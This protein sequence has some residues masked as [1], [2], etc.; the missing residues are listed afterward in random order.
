MSK[1]KAEIAEPLSDAQL[2]H[3]SISQIASIRIQAELL[4]LNLASG[5]EKTRAGL[6]TIVGLT[7]DVQATLAA[8]L[9]QAQGD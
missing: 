5:D 4:L 9:A 8:L 2:L 3:N 7:T 1:A 6:D